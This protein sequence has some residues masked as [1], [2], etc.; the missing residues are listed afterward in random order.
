M[1]DLPLVTVIMPV[2]NEAAYIERSLGAALGQDYPAGRLEILVVDGM[3]TDGTRE[4]VRSRQA[5][6]PRLRLIDNERRIVAP[7]LNL[8]VRQARGDIVV[9]VDGHCEIAPD[10]VRR[11][12][13]HLLADGVEAVGGPIETVGETEAARAIALAM[14]SWFGVGGSAFRTVKDRPLLV[15][16]VAFPAYTRGTL[17]R[18]G[19][20]DEEL[21]RNQDDEY[22]YRLLK[23]GGRILLSPDIRSR[24]Y[25]RGGLRALWRQYY[26]YGFWKVRVMWKHPRQM[27]PRQFVPPAFAG[28]LIGSSALGLL[29]RPLWWALG[30][31]LALY[32]LADVAATA[33]LGR[34]HGWQYAPRLLIIHPILHLS[35]GLGFLAGL[36]RFAGRAKTP[37]A[38]DQSSALETTR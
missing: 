8:G 37:L 26:Q 14:S 13:A 25:S 24:Y 35:Y 28:L 31:G 12:V 27:R 4:Y 30:L 2:R 23:G 22:N 9:R 32:A 17:A 7:G 10:Y 16:T 34:A 36:A 5:N 29:F 38:S 21:V 19:P 11:C 6:D 15:E 20:F 33:A 1:E 3:S 18:L